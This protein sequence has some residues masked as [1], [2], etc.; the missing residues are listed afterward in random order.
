MIISL[1]PFALLVQTF[2]LCASFTEVPQYSFK[3]P[4]NSFDNEGFRKVS[5]WTTSGSAEVFTNYIRLT[6]DRASKQGYLWLEE[7][8][9]NV[10]SISLTVRFRVSGQGKV[11]FG[12]GFGL[13]LLKSPTLPRGDLHGIRDTF[14]GVGVIFD[15]YNNMIP[16]KVHKD[17]LLL[18]SDG[19]KSVSAPHG[20]G[21]DPLIIGCDADFRYYEGRDDFSPPLNN[22]RARI[23]ISDNKVSIYID[24]RSRDEWKTCVEN[25]P[26]LIS[27]KNWISSGVHIAISG[28]T[29]DLADNHD[30]LSLQVGLENE[31]PSSES[32]KGITPL[33]S[34]LSSI[35]GANF[36]S[37]GDERIDKSIKSSIESQFSLLDQHITDSQHFLEHE[38]SK[39]DDGLK[40]SIKKILESERENTK[41]IEELEK[42]LSEQVASKIDDRIGKVEGTVALKVK[43]SKTSYFYMFS[44]LLL[45][46]GA[47]SYFGYTRYRKLLKSHLL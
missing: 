32:D 22:S 5:G 13:W 38:L 20:G 47:L 3:P 15:T 19:K 42:R 39:L 37:T 7:E 4:Y 46:I 41:R 11:L 17:I 27:D 40:S 9:K 28:T 6:N 8:L 33:S 31:S 23:F 35:L 30:I 45:I 14:V 1:L 16:G 2:L 18:T 24:P 44:F 21:A 25:S 43:E 10:N 34:T 12:D 29:G 36:V 26:I